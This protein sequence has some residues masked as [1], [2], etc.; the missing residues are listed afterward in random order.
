MTNFHYSN[1][2]HYTNKH[3]CNKIIVR[4][5]VSY[6]FSSDILIMGFLYFSLFASSVAVPLHKYGLSLIDY[7]GRW[8]CGATTTTC[9][10]VA[11]LTIF[12]SKITKRKKRNRNKD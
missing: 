1:C 3:K 7:Q 8:L 4:L 11:T 5:A 12:C 9:T 6:R 2:R 10:K